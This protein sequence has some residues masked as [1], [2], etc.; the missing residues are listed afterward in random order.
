MN[1]VILNSLE[2]VMTAILVFFFLFIYILTMNG[3]SE[4]ANVLSKPQ[5]VTPHLFSS[6]PSSQTSTASK[7]T[8]ASP[9]N[10]SL[11]RPLPK[12][13]SPVERTLPT[14]NTPV[15][16]PL[17]KANPDKTEFYKAIPFTLRHE[18][19]L[20]NDKADR[21]GI[22]KYGISYTYLRHLLAHNTKLL[23]A[24]S[25]THT[26]SPAI[27]KHMTKRQAIRT[28]IKHMT[29]R[30][31]IR[32]YFTQWW[33]KYHFGSIK[34]QPIATKAFDYAVNMGASPAIRLLQTA[35]RHKAGSHAILVNGKLDQRT[36]EYINN[37][38][39]TLG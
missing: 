3:N 16:R 9:A 27:I 14:V 6:V 37:L 35:C 7:E 38:N 19:G 23:S 24:L 10:K 13:N 8:L 39:P 29:K 26:I 5:V 22:T 11:E 30:Q 28:I 2:K 21:G 18:G 12:V 1:K 15:E 20:V 25:S 31:A 4:F 33:E 17:P 36:T 34:K 32:I